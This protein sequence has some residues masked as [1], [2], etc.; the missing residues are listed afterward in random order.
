[1][2][3][4]SELIANRSCYICCCFSGKL[5]WWSRSNWLPCGKGSA[6][7]AL[8]CSWLVGWLWGISTSLCWKSQNRLLFFSG[9]KR[10][11]VQHARGCWYFLVSVLV[12]TEWKTCPDDLFLNQMCT[13]YTHTLYKCMYII[14]KA[15]KR[16]LHDIDGTQNC[17]RVQL[18]RKLN[19]LNF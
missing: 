8:E 15:W 3:L 5:C 14:P 4:I 13:S 18:D 2:S 10:R 6:E 1:M 11:I 9:H 12:C 19:N 17:V 7:P 16:T